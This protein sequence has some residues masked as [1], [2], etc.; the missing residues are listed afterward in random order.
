MEIQITTEG[1][2]TSIPQVGCKMLSEG[3][4]CLLGCP[5]RLTKLYSPKNPKG[6]YNMVGTI[7]YK[8]VTLVELDS[9]ERKRT[10]VDVI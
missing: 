7:S 8:L 9:A 1:Q 10:A 2:N 5:A 4:I 3:R 6:K